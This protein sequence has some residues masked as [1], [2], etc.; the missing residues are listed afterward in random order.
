MN[1]HAA[2]CYAAA[3]AVVRG[4]QDLVKILAAATGWRFSAIPERPK[5]TLRVHG[6]LPS[7]QALAKLSQE[8]EVQLR[9]LHEPSKIVAPN[10]LPATPDTQALSRKAT[11]VYM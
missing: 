10:T 5:T 7:T 9:S 2:V 4:L 1:I 6:G 11:G 8:H 3:A